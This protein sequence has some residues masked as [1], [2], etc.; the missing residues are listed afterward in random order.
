LKFQLAI[1]DMSE[2]DELNKIYSDFLNAMKALIDEYSE[3][4]DG[5]HGNQDVIP[6]FNPN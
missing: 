6:K 3:F 2:N 4:L 1:H 5:K